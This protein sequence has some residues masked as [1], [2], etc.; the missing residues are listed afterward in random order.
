MFETSFTG[1]SKNLLDAIAV[2]SEHSINLNTQATA[3]VGDRFVIKFLSGSEEEEVR[4]ML[5]KADLY[6]KDRPVLVVSMFNKPGQWLKV[7]HALVD[8]GIE[9]LASYLMSQKGDTQS[10]V[11]AVSGYEGARKICTRI[12]EC[13]VD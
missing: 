1:S 12:A 4:R 5:M 13:S 3:K 10:Y 2:L 7:A 9:I 6:Y 11:F 8:A